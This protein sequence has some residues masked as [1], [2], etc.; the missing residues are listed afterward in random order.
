MVVKELVNFH[1]S[2]HLL[3]VHSPKRSTKKPQEEIE[4]SRNWFCEGK[5][6][7]V[8]ADMHQPQ[9]YNSFI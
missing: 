8:P 9:A 4:A 6:E 5:P 3:P 7:E 1:S 2:L